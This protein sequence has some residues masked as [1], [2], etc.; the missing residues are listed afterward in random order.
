MWLVQA[1]GRGRGLAWST[2]TGRRS[3][4]SWLHLCRA[5]ERSA[6]CRRSTA[7]WSP[8]TDPTWTAASPPRVG[9]WPLTSDLLTSDLLTSDLWPLPSSFNSRLSLQ[10]VV[11]TCCLCMFVCS[12]ISVI[13]IQLPRVAQCQGNQQPIIFLH[14]P[15]SQSAVRS[16][17]E[18]RRLGPPTTRRVREREQ[19]S[20]ISVKMPT[21]DFRKM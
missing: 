3:L 2:R 19:I 13:S 14:S 7:P 1:W 6:R 21:E 4:L 11:I 16:G 15:E 17:A 20:Q 5:R 9:D 12:S 8:G 18:W 10:T